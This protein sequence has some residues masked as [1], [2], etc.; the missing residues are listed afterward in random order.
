MTV[1]ASRY[2]LSDVCLCLPKAH[3]LKGLVSRMVLLAG[4]GRSLGPWE[5]VVRWALPV[6]LC[7]LAMKSTVFCALCILL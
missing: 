6:T 3:I 1:C 7:F 2:G 5:H 4:G